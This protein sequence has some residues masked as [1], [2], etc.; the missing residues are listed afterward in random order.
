MC[1]FL[2]APAT[3][4]SSTAVSG[5]SSSLFIASPFGDSGQKKTQQALAV[6]VLDRLVAG[7]DEDAFDKSSGG[8]N[9]RRGGGDGV[10]K[11]PGAIGLV[12]IL[13]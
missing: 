13:L 10:M 1:W 9:S 12:R 8:V 7:A 3:P 5:C 2:S 6:R 11:R 4:W